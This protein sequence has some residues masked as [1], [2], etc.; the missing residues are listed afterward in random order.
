MQ[1]AG[2]DDGTLDWLLK[3]SRVTAYVEEDAG[4]Y[5]AI[6]RGFRRA[7]GEIVA[8]LNCD[9]QYLP[10]ALRHVCDVFAA[11]PSIDVLFGDAIVIKGDG[12]YICH[13]K[14]LMP[15]K[16]HM[17][18]RFTVLTCSTF[19]RRKLLDQHRIYFDTSWRVI[20]DFFWVKEML[21]RRVPMA[22]LRRYTSAFADT[23]ENLSLLP[24]AEEERQRMREMPPFWVRR[25]R[26]I[27]ILHHRLR[28]LA[29][30][31]Y[32]QRP[33]EYSV[34]TR[35]SPERRTAFRVDKPTGIWHERD[36]Q[37]ARFSTRQ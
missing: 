27:L 2:S 3:D 30:G 9:E 29:N 25:L 33:F 14:A 12:R 8:Y 13:R 19:L 10:G 17:W 32:S 35:Q 1:D 6:N 24:G 11:H 37:A 18:Y 31:S 22:L 28:M 26:P 23:G 20:G 7:K 34:Y 16:S 4:M 36:R 15:I 5:D 21:D